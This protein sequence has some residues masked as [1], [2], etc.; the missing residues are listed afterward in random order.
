MEF[1]SC[2]R[3]RVLMNVVACSF[4]GDRCFQSKHS[5]CFFEPAPLE[6]THWLTKPFKAVR[7]VHIQLCFLHD[8]VLSRSAK[9]LRRQER[10]SLERTWAYPFNL[11]LSLQ[12]FCRGKMNL[13][14]WRY[15]DHY[16]SILLWD[17]V[18][19]FSFM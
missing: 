8:D 16:C 4:Y 3:N 18:Y 12:R 5:N 6:P 2:R 14:M 11:Q 1:A 10:W 17:V 15:D 13:S 19:S 7:H 9:T